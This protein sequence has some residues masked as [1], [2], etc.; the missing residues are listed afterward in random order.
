MRPRQSVSAPALFRI[1][2]R[3]GED[4]VQIK[5][6]KTQVSKYEQ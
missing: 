2:Q 5:A 1:G 6:G 3:A 4:Q